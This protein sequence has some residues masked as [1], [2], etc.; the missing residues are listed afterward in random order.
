M[1]LLKIEDF[2]PDYDQVFVGDGD[3]INFDVYSDITNE[4]VGGV[5]DILVDEKDGRFRDLIVDLGFWIFGKQVLL[6]TGR[7]RI[8]YPQ[9][10]IYT[11]GLAKE[12]AKNLPEF[13]KELQIDD[14]YDS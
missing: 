6:P 8:N 3:I 14:D 11:K 10:R 9:Q 12:Q 1:E 2:H 4:K 13:T 5:K 7:S